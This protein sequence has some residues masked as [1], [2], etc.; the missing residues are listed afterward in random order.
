MTKTCQICDV[1]FK[2]GDKVVLVMLS[3]FRV[4]DSDVTYAV[5]EPGPRSCIE[6]LHRDCHG[7]PLDENGEPQEA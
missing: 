3:T 4:I 2:D 1:E 5:D 7:V 6:I